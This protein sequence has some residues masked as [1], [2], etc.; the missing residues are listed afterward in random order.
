MTRRIRVT[1]IRKTEPDIGLYVLALI[2][3]ARQLQAEAAATSA[4][5][6]E[7]TP[8]ESKLGEAGHD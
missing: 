5:Q 1:G 8:A 6:D 7:P 4:D 2:A 3:L